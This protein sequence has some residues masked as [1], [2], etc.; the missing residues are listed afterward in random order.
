MYKSEWTYGVDERNGPNKDVIVKWVEIKRIR[1]SI[2]KKVVIGISKRQ[3]S[4]GLAQP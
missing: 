2:A 3:D 1:N 4:A